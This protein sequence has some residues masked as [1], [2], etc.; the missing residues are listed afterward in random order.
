MRLSLIELV[1]KYLYI[2]SSPH[3]GSTLLSLVLG[4]HETAANL[5]EVSF[6][7]KLIAMGE[8]CTCGARLAECAQW[9]RIFTSLAASEHTDLRHAPY[10]YYLGDAIKDRHGS[11]LVDQVYQTRRRRIVAKLRGAADTAVLLASPGRPVLRALTPPAVKLSIRN[12][13]G[14]Y[15]AAAAALGKQLVIDAS[16]LPRK[17]PH[18]YLHEPERV[19]ILHLVRDG[20]GVVSS[21]M[22]YMPVDMASRRWRHYHSL[23]RRILHRWVSPAHRRQLRF[24]DF[25]A[26]PQAH[27]R[28]LCE[29]LEVD[30]SA[31]MLD[32]SAQ[33]VDHSAGG[34]P[35]RFEFSRGIRP[36][37]DRWRRVMSERD[38]ALFDS[39]AGK[40]NRAFGYD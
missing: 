36:A 29:W 11:G 8:S 24:E 15:R 17:A 10:G 14:L 35:A 6:I 32:F 13:T 23:T 37:D 39:I 18:L 1:M 22:R 21:R 4:R 27:L 19:R 16:K 7:P 34:N 25:V 2:V 3:G 26:D 33:R 12:T 28:A 5:G 30:Y 20:R 40:L 38:L 9:S 31:R